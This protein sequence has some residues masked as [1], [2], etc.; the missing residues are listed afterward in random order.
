[1]PN[2]SDLFR[3]KDDGIYICNVWICIDQC[4]LNNKMLKYGKQYIQFLC[5]SKIKLK[6]KCKLTEKY[7]ADILTQINI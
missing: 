1:M 7:N 5:K 2:K 4:R 3:C 6:Y